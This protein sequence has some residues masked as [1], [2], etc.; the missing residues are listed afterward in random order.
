[1]RIMGTYDSEEFQAWL[2]Q[3]EGESTKQQIQEWLSFLEVEP[4]ELLLVS[5]GSRA[6]PYCLAISKIISC[7][8]AMLM[9][10]RLLDA[11]LFDFVVAPLCHVGETIGNQR[12][13][14]DCH[15]PNQL[16]V[17]GVLN[18]IRKEELIPAKDELI[19]EFPP[20]REK[21]WAILL[22]GET[23]KLTFPAAWVEKELAPIFRKAET[24]N[25]DIYLTTSRRT[26]RATIDAI[27]SLGSSSPATRMLWL[28][29]EREG[30][31][32]PGML[33]LVDRVF[34]TNDSL[35]MVSE[36]MTSGVIFSIL[37]AYYT[38][39]KTLGFFH[40]LA[41]CF[42]TQKPP[43]TWRHIQ[44]NQMYETLKI[45]GVIK[46]PENDNF[47]YCPTIEINETNRAAKWV[48]SRWP[49]IP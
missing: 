6:A 24:E 27:R 33:G 46:D 42:K 20:H 15:P 36:T 19:K 23:R 30:N 35:S 25:A 9:L 12:S 47:A 1:M 45:L 16:N 26:A 22:G 29:S 37:P 21:R 32:I 38:E 8:S 11:A 49:D 43:L 31:P 28:A 13:H 48:L 7:R 3:A 4:R 34:C 40:R 14:A 10:T 39:N 41:M 44:E 5:S 17:I 2:R 18:R